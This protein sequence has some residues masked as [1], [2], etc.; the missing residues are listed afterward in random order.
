[1]ARMSRKDLMLAAMDSCGCQPFTPVQL[2][3]L[4][5][6]IDRQ[7]SSALGGPFFAFEPYDYGPFDKGV[8]ATA[9]SLAAQGLLDIAADV[10]TQRTYRLTD[11]GRARGDAVRANLDPAVADHISKLASF[12]RGQSFSGLV[13][14]IY[15]AYPEMR[16]HSVFSG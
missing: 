3:K 9:D 1:M 12:V 6:L 13:S 10:R 11:A 15:K 5:F 2:Q 8:Y 14:A 4:F 16:V 7:L